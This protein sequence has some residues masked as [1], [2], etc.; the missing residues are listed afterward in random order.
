MPDTFR[1]QTPADLEVAVLYEAHDLLADIIAPFLYQVAGAAGEQQI[2]FASSETLEL[3][4][5]RFGEFLADAS[6]NVP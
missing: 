3:F 4:V 5:I 6:A 2:V 1:I